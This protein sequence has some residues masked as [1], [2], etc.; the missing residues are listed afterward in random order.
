MY[1]YLEENHV[2][3]VTKRVDV[4]DKMPLDKETLELV[5]IKTQKSRRVMRMKKRNSSDEEIAQAKQEYN[6]ARNK[7]RKTTRLKRKKY[8]EN[9][10]SQVK[11]NPK[12]VYAY[13]NRK[14]KTKSGITDLC[15][16]PAN[17]KSM[18]TS[19]NKKKATIFSDFF[20]SVWTDEPDGPTPSFENRKVKQP[21]KELIITEEVVYKKLTELKVEKNA[22]P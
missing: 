1:R 19:S 8:E 4:K 2:P 11:R 17:P 18:R 7:V 5:K 16:D 6:R 22:G 20:A 3:T 12:P 10:A 13:M 15:I 9:I 21:M 14:S